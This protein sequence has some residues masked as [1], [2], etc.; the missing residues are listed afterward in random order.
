MKRCK[1][2]A[3]YE[4]PKEFL[5]DNPAKLYECRCPCLGGQRFLVNPDFGCT[6][7]EEKE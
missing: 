1:T 4:K 3:R 2:C 6:H 7:H 5:R